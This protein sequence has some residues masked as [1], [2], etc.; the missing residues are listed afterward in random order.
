[1]P[2]DGVRYIGELLEAL[3]YAHARGV[4]HRDIKPSNMMITAEDSVKLMDFGI[5]RAVSGQIPYFARH[6]DRI[7]R[8]HGAG[9]DP[10]RGAGSAVGFVFGGCD[11]IRTGERGAAV[12][13]GDSDY[14]IMTAHVRQAPTSAA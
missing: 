4:V 8:V 11:S 6:C 14:A 3:S 13:Q 7:G 5:A 1:M 9:A 12:Y 2:A 10:G